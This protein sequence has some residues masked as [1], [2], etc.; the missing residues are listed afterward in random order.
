ME[1]KNL[2]EEIRRLWILAC[3]YEGIDPSSSFVVFSKVNPFIERHDTLIRLRL[4][5]VRAC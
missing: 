4:A 3:Q 1:T 2:S 5:A